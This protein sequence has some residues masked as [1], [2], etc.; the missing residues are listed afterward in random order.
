M[1][2]IHSTP[3]SNYS[4]IVL[5]KSAAGRC[6]YIMIFVDYLV[7]LYT[8]GP[9]LAAKS[10]YLGALLQASSKLNYISLEASS[11]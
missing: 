7:G 10:N 5:L 2:R 6:C 4:I 11:F 3:S 1:G 8:Q 9:L